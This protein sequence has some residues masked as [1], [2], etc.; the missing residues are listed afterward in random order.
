[1]IANELKKKIFRWNV[2]R[3]KLLY[4]PLGWPTPSSRV[5]IMLVIIC[6]ANRCIWRR[7]DGSCVMTWQYSNVINLFYSKASKEFNGVVVILVCPLF[8]KPQSDLR[9]AFV[10]ESPQRQYLPWLT[11][12]MKDKPYQWK[13]KKTQI[14]KGVL[15]FSCLTWR[16]KKSLQVL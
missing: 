15:I 2:T 9:K 14:C 7:I 12:T 3:I 4:R 11:L 16:K 10:S 8:V 13:Q 5:S 6:Y 1:M